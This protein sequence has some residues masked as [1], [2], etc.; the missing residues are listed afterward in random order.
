MKCLE[1]LAL[2]SKWSKV[3]FNFRAEVKYAF[4]DPLE[5]C[6]TSRNRMYKFPDRTQKMA[7]KGGEGREGGW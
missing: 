7:K 6:E 2:L 1:I 4:G 3:V 5:T